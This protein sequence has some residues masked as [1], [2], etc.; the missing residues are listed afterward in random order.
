MMEKI[1]V[2]L[3]VCGTVVATAAVYVMCFS[4]LL[5]T[6]WFLL[7]SLASL[8]IGSMSVLY[9]FILVSPK[10][11][12]VIKVPAYV[13][14]FQ[15]TIQVVEYLQSEQVD[16]F[17]ISS[18]DLPGIGSCQENWSSFLVRPARRNEQERQH[19]TAES[20][21][22]DFQRLVWVVAQRSRRLGSR[23]TRCLFHCTNKV[24]FMLSVLTFM[25]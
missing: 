5:I 4:N 14:I 11:T 24:G 22:S 17:I 20:A 1:N 13:N 12:T 19:D 25:F 2:Q 9:I 15:R 8:L 6:T 18:T 21:R 3:A 23:N 16:N 7:S 10:H